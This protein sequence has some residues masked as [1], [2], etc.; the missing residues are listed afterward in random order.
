MQ[1][2]LRREGGSGVGVGFVGGASKVEIIEGPPAANGSGGPYPEGRISPPGVQQNP[3]PSPLHQETRG[4]RIGNKLLREVRVHGKGVRNGCAT[5]VRNG[6][7]L[8][9]VA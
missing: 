8:Q 9:R 1:A 4:D 7:V 5:G 2:G 6:F 3:S